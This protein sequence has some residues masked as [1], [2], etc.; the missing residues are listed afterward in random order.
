MIITSHPNKYGWGSF[1]KSWQ[2]ETLQYLKQVLP[3]CMLYIV[4]HFPP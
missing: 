2:G 3:F 1:F 4:A